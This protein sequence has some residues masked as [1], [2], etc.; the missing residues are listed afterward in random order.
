MQKRP[1][2]IR[3]VAAALAATA[4][5]AP[6]TACSTSAAGAT[7]CAGVGIDAGI[8]SSLSDAILYIADGRD[9]S[10]TKAWK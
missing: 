9:I 5:A 1:W 7:S 10:P 8:V 6:L 4:A 3:A 2:R